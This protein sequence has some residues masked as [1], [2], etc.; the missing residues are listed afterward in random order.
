ML[1][2]N[3]FKNLYVVKIGQL[4]YSQIRTLCLKLWFFLL[5]IHSLTRNI[6]VF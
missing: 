3:K 5:V 4:F 6:A 1:F 2:M